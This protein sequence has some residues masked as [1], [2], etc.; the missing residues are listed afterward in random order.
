MGVVSRAVKATLALALC[1]C[2]AVAPA[3]RS[4]PETKIVSRPAVQREPVDVLAR[5]SAEQTETSWIVAG[6]S[7]LILGGTSLQIHDGAPLLEVD[8]LEEQGNDVRVGI[9][10]EHARFALWTSRAR[11]LAVLTRDQH[12]DGEFGGGPDPIEV[13]LHTGAAVRRLA[14]KD[15]RTQ[16][17]YVGAVEVEGWVPDDLLAERGKAGRNNGRIY[18]GRKQLMVTPGSVIRTEPRWMGKQLAVMN[19]GYFLDT[20]K[21][22]DDA[23]VEVSFEDADVRVHGFVSR[24]DP[25]GRTHQRKSPEPAPPAVTPNVTVADHTCL[26]VEG[27]PV[28]FLTGDRE[29]LLDK[30]ERPNEFVLTIDSPW[31]AIEFEAHGPAETDLEKCGS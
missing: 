25:P 9:R 4:T 13:V 6:P 8:L 20:I 29:V 18:S 26:F 21:E 30:G 19:E 17:R 22:I 3:S 5:L 16:I 15:G 23:W 12:I 28:G 7:Q 14:K 11:L 31:G 24:H 1:A 27:E 10:L 2:G